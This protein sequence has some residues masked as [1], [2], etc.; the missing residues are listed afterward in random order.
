MGPDIRFGQVREIRERVSKTTNP[1]MLNRFNRE[2][3]DSETALAR[4]V[5]A[6]ADAT[7]ALDQR[8]LELS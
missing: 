1:V 7:A 6:K 4:S 2:L 8:V 3:A 5:V